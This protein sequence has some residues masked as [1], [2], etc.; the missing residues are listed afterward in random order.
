MHLFKSST[1]SIALVAA[2]VSYGGAS[3]AFAAAA[4]TTDVQAVIVTGTRTTGLKAVDSPAP[5]QVLDAGSLARVG[6]PDLTQSLAA[7]VPSFVAQ[8]FG[9]DTAN[10]TLSARLRGVSPNDTLVL[11]NGARRHGTANLAVLGGAFQGGAAPD[12]NFI[13]TVSIDH[14][15]VL[16]DG[17]AAQYGTDAIAGVVNIILKKN[18]SG[19]VVNVSG[20]EYMDQ[21]GKTADFSANVGFAPSTNSFLNLSFESKFHGHSDRGDI[22]PRIPG[23]TAAFPSLINAPGYPYLNHIRGDAQVRTTVFSFNGGIDLDGGLSLFADGSYGHKTGQSYENWRTPSK[24]FSNTTPKTYP[25]PFGFQ[26]SEELVE[27]DYSLTVGAKGKLAGW[28]FNVASTYGSDREQINVASSANAALYFDTGST[29]NFFH[30]GDFNDSQWTNTLD[31]T[32][33]F[34]LGLAKPLTVAF[35]AEYRHETYALVAGDPASYY[36]SATANAGGAQGATQSYPGFSPANAGRYSRDNTGIYIDLATSLITN[37]QVDAAVRFEHYSD[38]GDTTVAKLTGRYDFTPQIAVRGTISTGFRAPTLAEEHYSATNISPTSAALQLPPNS[39]EAIKLIGQGLKAEESTNYSVG[40]VFKPIPRLTATV[41]AYQIEITK[42]IIGSAGIYGLGSPSGQ[43]SADALTTF[44]AIEGAL[45]APKELVTLFY[46]GADTRTTG[47]EFVANYVSDLPG[48]GRIDWTLSG[49]TNTTKVT[50]YAKTSFPSI[51]PLKAPQ[52]LLDPSVFSI[53]QT[54]SP[55]YRVL[56]G[57][58]WTLGDFSANL[59]ETFYG[60]ASDSTQGDD[61]VFYT[62]TIKASAI[63]DLELAYKLPNNIK[64]AVGAQ[65]LFNK[66][67][68]KLN[69][70]LRASYK[71]AGDNSYVQQYPSYSPFGVNGGYYYGRVTYTF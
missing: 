38:F 49:A 70:G 59:R 28:D 71:A 22:D 56:V 15:E 27:N 54:L 45:T 8:A 1:S 9:G 57:A 30:N 55:K 62:T 43:N 14:V 25:Y 47:V 35:G 5:I 58:T 23:Q 51:N 65:N 48:F 16:T 17:A 64:I 46:N 53:L 3:T 32:H 50:K 60:K 7:N 67:P 19:G 24:V 66:Y 10:L 52:P 12:L 37:L 29:P 61:G 18:A 33:D 2:L 68:D 21:G 40:A 6:S 44:T 39:P 4:D 13:P 26:P 31:L 34:D 20:G 42:R 69:P 36:S 41:D 11:V 63:T